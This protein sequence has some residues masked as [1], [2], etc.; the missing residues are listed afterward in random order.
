MKLFRLLVFLCWVTVF[1]QS[2]S[3]TQNF[4]FFILDS[5]V[6]F[7]SYK[8]VTKCIHHGSQFEHTT[9]SPVCSTFLLSLVHSLP[10]CFPRFL[11]QSHQL[12]LP[13]QFLLIFTYS[14][15][16]CLRSSFA[17]NVVFADRL[18]HFFLDSPIGA[19]QVLHLSL[20]YLMLG[21]TN[22]S[23]D[24]FVAH[25]QTH[26]Q[27]HTHARTHSHAHTHTYTTIP[28]G[29]TDVLCARMLCNELKKQ[30]QRSS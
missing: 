8:N 11:A 16:S 22:R 17:S 13:I 6:R 1:S 9:C 29:Q 4:G 5:E 26:R 25:G 15:S 18:V 23:F 24:S 20:L 30:S 19:T 28:F 14:F 21:D 10:I 27:T 7:P 2:K 3:F 12:F